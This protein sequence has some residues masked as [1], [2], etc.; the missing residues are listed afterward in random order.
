M[1]EEVIEIY[2]SDDDI[3]DDMASDDSSSLPSLDEDQDLDSP[4]SDGD[5]IFGTVDTDISCFLEGYK[6]GWMEEQKTEH[7][8]KEKQ[9][10]Q[11]TNHNGSS[12][13][14]TSSS[15][16]SRDVRTNPVT[17]NECLA[18]RIG[19]RDYSMLH[20]VTAVDMHEKPNEKS[21]SNVCQKSLLHDFQSSAIACEDLGTD[22]TSRFSETTV[23]L[24]PNDL[25]V[26]VEN[27]IAR[28]P[29]RLAES[30][31]LGP[32]TM[33]PQQWSTPMVP[34]VIGALTNPVPN[35]NGTWTTHD[36]VCKGHR[37]QNILT[38]KPMKELILG[39]RKYKISEP[40]LHASSLMAMVISCDLEHASCCR[41]NPTSCTV[42]HNE[43]DVILCTAAI[44][45]DIMQDLQETNNW[46]YVMKFINTESFNYT[47]QVF[48]RGIYSRQETPL[49]DCIH[50]KISFIYPKAIVPTQGFVLSTAMRECFDQPTRGLIGITQFVLVIECHGPRPSQYFSYKLDPMHERMAIV[51]ICHGDEA[52]PHC[53]CAQ[54]YIDTLVKLSKCVGTSQNTEA[55]HPLASL[56]AAIFPKSMST[57][58]YNMFVL[59][60]ELTR[61]SLTEVRI[62]NS[63]SGNNV[64]LQVGNF[65][66]KAAFI[67]KTNTHS[68]C[69]RL[70]LFA[71]I[72]LS[73]VL[74]KSVDDVLNSVA[75][76]CTTVLFMLR[77]GSP[78][79]CKEFDKKYNKIVK[80]ITDFFPQLTIKTIPVCKQSRPTASHLTCDTCDRKK[81]FIK[82]GSSAVL[83]CDPACLTKNL[84]TQLTITKRDCQ[85]KGRET[86]YSR[87]QPSKS[88]VPSQ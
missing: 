43:Q 54:Q 59:I 10:Q 68:Y 3:L 63:M 15:S 78:D 69:H 1:D 86:P 38:R 73:R 4:D 29:P 71:E 37:G 55:S 18:T 41:P 53:K 84:S 5:L 65:D 66:H 64:T 36:L 52:R 46:P 62:D 75:Q 13:L 14:G 26:A 44:Y 22:I 74:L 2:D 58:A 32:P 82:M 70:A 80:Q 24:K 88:Q 12:R 76:M 81:S 79:R 7:R 35:M 51:C 45:S 20:E 67:K 49:S 11:R 50:E 28:D 31:T 57:I 34:Y 47:S 40:K 21:T 19:H 23:W 87:T 25:L 77:Y 39:K 56:H 83:V 33:L 8:N 30:G 16:T 9:I 48:L 6:G 60:D 17:S 27:K 42:H 72:H 61:G 85:Q